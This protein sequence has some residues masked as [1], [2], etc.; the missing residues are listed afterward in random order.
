MHALG[1]VRYH[2]SKEQRQ[3]AEEL[4]SGG[5][6]SRFSNSGNGTVS[7]CLSSAFLSVGYI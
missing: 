1:F 5:A 6:S 4:V 7:V 2:N 3:I